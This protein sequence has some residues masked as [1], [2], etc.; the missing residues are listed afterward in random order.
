MAGK[1]HTE[2]GQAQHSSDEASSRGPQEGNQG[3]TIYLQ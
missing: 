3:N 2:G 1:P